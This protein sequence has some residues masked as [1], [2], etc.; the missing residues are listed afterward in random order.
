MNNKHFET[1]DGFRGVAAIAV[2][3]YHLGMWANR[4]WLFAHGYLAVDFF[5]CLSG[6]I[7]AYIYGDRFDAGMKFKDFFVQRIIRL[8]PVI[9]IGM[10]MGLVFN[11]LRVV[12]DESLGFG[13][14]DVSLAYAMSIF[15]VPFFGIK[16]PVGESIYPLNSPFWSIF[17]EIVINIFWALGLRRIKPGILFGVSAMVSIIAFSQLE[18]MNIGGV[19]DQLPWGL[20]RV[21]VGFSAG[22]W[23][24]QIYKAGFKV[25]SVGAMP[26]AL[27][28]AAIFSLPHWKSIWFD[29]ACI[30]VVFPGITLLGIVSVSDGW[31]GR[32]IDW[33]GRI[34][35][36]IYG[37]HR[38]IAL[39]LI[40]II[41]KFYRGP[42]SSEVQIVAGTVASLV[43]AYIL[44][45]WIDEPVRS[46]LRETYKN[47]SKRRTKAIGPS[48]LKDTA[49]P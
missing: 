36:P 17:F 19:W 49:A 9:F 29:L 6:F 22:L 1:L 4:P 10:T 12:T 47:V 33:A 32:C 11:L 31:F 13:F 48:K 28:L 15:L 18:Y 3:L 40:T 38:P 35:Y 46:W 42:F 21:T 2:V 25:P 39:G 34:S 23:V 14:L 5:F 45:R 43:G 26:L 44:V 7:I 16:S 30:L 27:I 24:H 20:L 41:T 8:Y 37:V